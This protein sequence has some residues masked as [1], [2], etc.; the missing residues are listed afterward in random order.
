M[1]FLKIRLLLRSADTEEHCV[2]RYLPLKC[3][4]LQ[5][6]INE[7]LNSVENDWATRGA[8]HSFILPSRT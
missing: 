8:Q 2:V 5:L 7:H 4:N 1:D 6:D 3:Q